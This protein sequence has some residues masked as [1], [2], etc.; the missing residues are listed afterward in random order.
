MIGLPL[1][2]AFCASRKRSSSG[3]RGGGGGRAACETQGLALKCKQAGGPPREGWPPRMVG[4]GGP[5]P[6]QPCSLSRAPA[7]ARPPSTE[8]AGRG[9][10]ES[11]HP[12]ARPQQLVLEQVKL[13]VVDG[14]LP[15]KVVA[16]ERLQ[17]ELLLLAQRQGRQAL[18]RIVQA[19]VRIDVAVVHAG[20][21]VWQ[22]QDQVRRKSSAAAPAAAAAAAAAR[23]VGEQTPSAPRSRAASMQ[24]LLGSKGGP[25]GRAL[26]EGTL[27]QRRGLLL[28]AGLDCQASLAPS[29]SSGRAVHTRCQPGCLGKRCR[30]LHSDQQPRRNFK[31]KRSER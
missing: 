1:L 3:L 25:G 16:G 18:A 11:R 23:A 19:A 22:A 21:M 31:G 27:T 6:P 7:A 29:C 20:C 5:H 10:P 12:A 30:K 15:V 9:P 4:R 13:L 2:A 14:G 8:P 24:R 17:E 26:G 28:C